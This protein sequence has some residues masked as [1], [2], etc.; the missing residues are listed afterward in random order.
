[1]EG[2]QRDVGALDGHVDAQVGLVGVLPAQVGVIK[3]L[4]RVGVVGIVRF[5]VACRR[6]GEGQSV[7][8]RRSG[9]EHLEGRQFDTFPPSCMDT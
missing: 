5:V 7:C 2:R 3:S 1:M 6:R 4:R 9:V 8:I